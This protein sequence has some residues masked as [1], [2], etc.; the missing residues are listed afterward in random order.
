MMKKSKPFPRA[1]GK[2]TVQRLKSLQFY[3]AEIDEAYQC[4]ENLD[5]LYGNNADHG[6]LFLSL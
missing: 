6:I 2:D 5:L 1:G 3:Q 4:A